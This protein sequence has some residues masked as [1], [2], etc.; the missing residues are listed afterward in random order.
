MANVNLKIISGHRV[1]LEKKL[2]QELFSDSPKGVEELLK[3]LKT[4]PKALSLK[5]RLNSD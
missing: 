3:K 2:V 5:R 4:P 1:S